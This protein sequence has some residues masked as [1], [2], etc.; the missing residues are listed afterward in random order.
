MNGVIFVIINLLFWN[1]FYGQIKNSSFSAYYFNNSKPIHSSIQPYLESHQISFDTAT[2]QYK[3]KWA[4]K[5]FS[6][7]L[8]NVVE[9]DIHIIADPLFNFTLSQRNE[10]LDFRYYSNVR[11]FRITG[12]LV[13]NFSFETRFYENQFYYPDY[14][15]LK[16][17]ERSNPSMGVDGIGLA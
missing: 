15:K 16:S 8:L 13:K 9:K 5:L 12:D 6:E 2:K 4:K 14:L 3:S 10:N 17:D 11:G 1:A 7:S